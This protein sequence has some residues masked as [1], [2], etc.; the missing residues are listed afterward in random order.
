MTM[1]AAQSIGLQRD[2]KHFK[3]PQLECELRRRLWWHIHSADSRVAEDHGLSVPEND[4]GDTE[5]PLNIDDGNLSGLDESPVESQSRWTEMTFSLIIMEVN[6][7]RPMLLR[8]LEG[9]TDP[10]GAIADFRREIHEK[11]LKHGDPDI[12]IQRI[13]LLLGQL[14]L[15]K[16]EVCIRQKI[17]HSQ[18]PA[19]TS[20]DRGIS[21]GS[22]DL[23][24][25]AI[26]L[27]LEI[28]TDEL[29]RGFRWLTSTFTGF[30]PLTYILWTLCVCPTGPHVERAWRVVNTLFDITEEDS[31]IPDPG[32]KWPLIVRLRE[33]ALRNRQAH[34]AL[35]SSQQVA[36]DTAVYGD[37]G[38]AMRLDGGFDMNFWDPSFIENSDWNY[39]TQSLG[40]LNGEI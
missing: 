19:A 28:H 16:A 33:K 36:D 12:P 20:L 17:I 37:G 7:K 40:L 6:R 32:A 22:F 21:Q 11:Y 1:R 9:S 2:G 10:S 38:S 25:N 8:T 13:G 30:H 31:L 34:E 3:L 23:A 18:G 29:L 35:H 4:Y 39:L 14:L 26:E 5:L 15:A 24:C 27:G